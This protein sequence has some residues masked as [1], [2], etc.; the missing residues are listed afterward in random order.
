MKNLLAP[1]S[2]AV[3]LST[4]AFAQEA[5]Q[6]APATANPAANADAS[7][8]VV[9]TDHLASAILG[10]SVYNSTA[11]NAEEIGEVKDIVI[12]ANGAAVSLIVGVGGFLGIGERNVAVEFKSAKWAEKAGDRWLVVETSKEQLEALPPFDAA[13]YAPL[14]VMETAPGVPAADPAATAPAAQPA[15]ATSETPAVTTPDEP[16]PADAPVEG[17]NSFTE[18]QAKSRMEDGGYTDVSALTKDDQGIWRGKATKDG[19]EV[20]VSLD[21]QGN[22][23]AN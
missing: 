18:A 21:Y 14:P 6:P 3:L 8:Q 13:V 12:D 7:A 2:I 10:E 4:A 1:L 5:T 9:T 19:K 17:A 23:V 22:V 15:P 11:E 16:A 20:S